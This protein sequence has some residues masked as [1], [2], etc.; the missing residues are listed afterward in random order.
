MQQNQSI[1]T[2]RYLNTNEIEQL[3]QKVEYI[4]MAAPSPDTFMLDAP[5]HF[6]IFLNTKEPLPVYVKDAVFDK[7]LEE[8]DIKDPIHVMAQM[9]P[10]GFAVSEQSTPMPMLLIQ[11]QDIASIPHRYMYVFDFLANSNS[12]DEVKK[13]SLTGWTYSYE[14]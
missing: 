5:I 8:N 1:K 12:F 10:V 13:D 9:A 4:I 7:F 11:P 3:L 14:D 2:K 6:T